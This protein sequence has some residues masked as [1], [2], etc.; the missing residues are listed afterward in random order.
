MS[1]CSPAPVPGW[2]RPG[3]YIPHAGKLSVL[4]LANAVLAL[5]RWVI[6]EPVYIIARDAAR[7]IPRARPHSS[8]LGHP[9]APALESQA[10]PPPPSTKQQGDRVD[11][12]HPRVHAGSTKS[13]ATLMRPF[14]GNGGLRITAFLQTSSGLGVGGKETEKRTG[15]G[16][17]WHGCEEGSLPN[18]AAIP[19]SARTRVHKS[20]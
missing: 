14:R 9:L 10:C 4:P 2:V 6:T 11:S 3:T 18:P 17:G 7:R 13:R 8:A 1:P 16:G 19:S 12:S 15:V 5:R 20:P